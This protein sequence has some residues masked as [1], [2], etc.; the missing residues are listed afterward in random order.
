MKLYTIFALLFYS[1]LVFPQEVTFKYTGSMNF[2]VA[3]SLVAPYLCTVDSAGILWVV[4]TNTVKASAIHS[5]FNAAPG[6]EELTLVKS[7]GV[8]DSVRDITGITAIG[9]DIFISARITAPAGTDMPDYYPYSEIFYLPDGDADAMVTL[10]APGHVYGTWYT[11]ITSTKDQYIYFGQSYLVTL[12]SIDARKGTAGFGNTVEYARIDWS[13]PMEPGGGLAY[14]NI[15]NMIRDVTV[16]PSADYNDT[17]V[18][19]YTSRNSSSDPGGENTGGIAVWTG[20]T[21]ANPLAYHAAR[22]SDLSGYLSFKS[23]VP[24]GIAVHPV[25]K[26]L[27]VCGTDDS[28]KWVKGFFITGNYAIQAAELPGSTSADLQDPEGAPFI[29]PADVVFSSDGNTAYVADEGALR[30]FKFSAN[31]TDVPGTASVIKSFE[32]DQNYPNPF[33]PSTSIRVYVPAAS[34]LKAEVYNVI[35]QK[36]ALLIDKEVNSGSHV[37][38]FD[39]SGLSS[40]VYFCKVDAGNYSK[41]IKMMINK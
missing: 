33:N 16:D 17:S 19:V 21:Q 35:G 23:S 18:V 20:G 27:F 25:T 39:A 13:T 11:A 8:E 30:V 4:S 7:F 36:V 41:T 38:S 12:G 26:N 31:T 6:D 2:P 3:D 24:Y 5:V 32:V 40:G 34:R 29:A 22:I 37:L 1:I 28:K 9:K 10:K 14:P 15:T